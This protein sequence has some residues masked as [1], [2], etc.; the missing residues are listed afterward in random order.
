MC[1]FYFK[2]VN[3][4]FLP[5]NSCSQKQLMKALHPQ[6]KMAVTGEHWKSF[7]VHTLINNTHTHTCIKGVIQLS[8]IL[9]LPVIILCWYFWK[10]VSVFSCS[11]MLPTWN[12][13]FAWVFVTLS[14]KF[15]AAVWV[16]TV[17]INNYD[18]CFAHHDNIQ[19][20]NPNVQ[21]SPCL[22]VRTWA[23]SS[24]ILIIF[25]WACFKAVLRSW[26]FWQCWFSNSHTDS[27][28]PWQWLYKD[29]Q[30]KWETQQAEKD[31]ISFRTKEIK[32]NSKK[33]HLE[34]RPTRRK[35]S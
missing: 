16:W 12:N 8:A 11:A 34:E 9:S 17:F 28:L 24:K 2:D 25:A 32:A 19:P 22:T 1:C 10:L 13:I 30:N 5:L 14:V 15:A 18:A 31:C 23:N 29:C 7:C 26:N 6:D 21:S 20:C 3:M 33:G 35:V 27:V 4:K